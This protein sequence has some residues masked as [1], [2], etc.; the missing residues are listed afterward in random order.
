M[1]RF[2]I[3]GWALCLLGCPADP[4]APIDDGDLAPHA[5]GATDAD[6]DAARDAELDAPGMM[7]LRDAA[8]GDAA[9]DGEVDQAL[10]AGV[11]QRVVDAAPDG[12]ILDAQPDLPVIDAAPLDMAPPDAAPVD[13]QPLDA[14]PDLAPLDMQPADMQPVDMAPDMGPDPL[15]RPPAG[16]CA[17]DR[18]FGWACFGDDRACEGD[19]TCIDGLCAPPSA[20]E[21][22]CDG[23]ADC[24]PGLALYCE[25]YTP[26]GEQRP[27][28]I[29]ALRTP[30]NGMCHRRNFGCQPGLVCVEDTC[31]QR[32][33]VG[34]ACVTSGDCDL[35]TWCDVDARCAP[36][37]QL[38]EPCNPRAPGCE[39]GLVCTDEVCSERAPPGDGC[40]HAGDC[41][42]GQYCDRFDESGHEREEAICAARLLEGTPCDAREV[43]ICNASVCLEGRC[44][45]DQPEEGA[46]RSTFD[47][48]AEFWCPR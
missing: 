40:R 1:T 32:G 16:F 3:L 13:M 35:A 47:C 21:G 17:P 48:E 42:V 4:A 25:R 2:V 37:I 19:L 34:S 27:R 6:L 43:S 23:T 36:F 9:R 11:D 22:P 28:P 38:G 39:P 41:A 14:A 18:P 31:R 10:D 26:E 46:C 8:M 45:A 24:L 15:A 44:V 12:S 5:D 20:R 33:G 30:E 7:M 29:C